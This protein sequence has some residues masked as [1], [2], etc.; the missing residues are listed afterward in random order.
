MKTLLLSLLLC[1]LTLLA[2]QPAITFKVVGGQ[3]ET[4]RVMKPVNGKFYMA[5]WQTDTLN[6]NGELKIT[7]KDRVPGTYEFNYKKAYRLYVRPGQS[8]TLTIEKDAPLKITAADEE[9][10]QAL[11]RLPAEFYQTVAMRYYKADTAFANNKTKVHKELDEQLAAFRTLQDQQK[12]SRGLYQYAEKYLK[13]YYANLLACTF[14][15][16]MYN[17]EFN[18]DSARYDAAKIKTIGNY[19]KDV[20][21]ISD[22]H[23][24]TSMNVSSYFDYANFYNAWYLEY[25][26]PVSKGTFK[27]PGNSPDEYW[28]RKYAVIGPN[29]KEPLREYLYATWIYALTM[30]NGFQPFVLNWFRDFNNTYPR[31]PYSAQLVAGVNK[32]RDY[33]DKI[34]GSFTTNQH[35]VEN[36]STIDSFQQLAEKFKGQ[37]VY[38]DLWA[39]WCGP[40][41]EEFQYNDS[42]K[43]F[44]KKNN[45]QVL[46]VSIDKEAADKQWKDMIRYYDLQGYHVRASANMFKDIVN[47][48]GKKGSIAIPR[49]AIIKDGKM[50]LDNAKRPS[51]KD[52][53]YRQIAGFL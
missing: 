12:I 14:I 26:L 25:F 2:Q 8:Y 22:V 11:N 45:I 13:T 53:L 31:S 36:Y 17:L 33:Q 28:T 42:L 16:P 51:D 3:G 32:V 23:D 37:T 15:T 6:A 9:G 21:A 30:E 4:V 5:A 24:T 34:K 38:V 35:F 48:F 39:T 18:K 46:Y 50:V 1:P 27:K 41:K 7:N 44:L 43:I 40:C 47:I 52:E 20:L 19:W 10:Q 29:Y 49:Y